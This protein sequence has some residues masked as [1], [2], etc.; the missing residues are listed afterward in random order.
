MHIIDDE[1]KFDPSFGRQV[2]LL[3][4]RALR[5][6]RR[7]EGGVQ[8]M[9]MKEGGRQGSGRCRGCRT[10]LAVFARVLRECLD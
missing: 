7:E 9:H 2:R 10:T 5:C 8:R 6:C 3:L 1:S 4:A